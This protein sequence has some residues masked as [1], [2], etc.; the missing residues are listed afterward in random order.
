MIMKI[1][2][3]LLTLICIFL[4]TACSSAPETAQAENVGKSS[5]P[6]QQ[7]LT[8]LSRDALNNYTSTFEIQFDGAQKW[9]Y[10]LKTRKTPSLSEVNLHMDGIEKSA[11]PGDV[12][13]VTDGT[14]SWMTGPGT[15]QECVQYPNRQG[16]DPTLA[17]PE[18][19]VS[20]SELSGLVSYVGE[21][22]LAGTTSAHYAGSNLTTAKWKN[23]KIEIW[24]DKTS[25]ALMKFTLQASGTDPFFGTGTGKIT[26]HYQVDGL[27]AGQIEAVKG[28]EI[29]VPLPETAKNFVRL[30]G[31][32]SFESQAGINELLNFY[33]AQMP[34]ANWAE[35]Q[36]P[37]QAE[38]ATVLSYTRNT[39][40]VEIHIEAAP[41]GGS[42]VKLLFL[43]P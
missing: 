14:T 8:G 3:S 37:A 12:R 22:A 29:N 11:N 26:A 16:L 30:P 17:D 10:Q 13:L 31:M 39:E 4:V 33:Q 20:F 27:D 28:C 9:T 24:Q 38:G 25:Q 5:N 41:A 7:K 32:A 42:Q 34:S 6:P 43:K 1:R 23:A 36:P 2:L 40:E 35:N 21:E 19:L 18:Q 15:D